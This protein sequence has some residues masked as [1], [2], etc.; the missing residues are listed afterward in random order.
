MAEPLPPLSPRAREA[1]ID[2][3]SR[4]FANDD[5]TLE[6]LERRI[7]RVYKAVTTADLEA[8]TADLRT[9][10]LPSSGGALPARSARNAARADAQNGGFVVPS[11][12]DA[13]PTRL[14][15]IMSTTRR[16]GRWSV[17][18]E[19][20]VLALMSDTRLDLTSAAMPGGVVTVHVNAIMASFRIIVP[21][22][23]RIINQMH[24]FMADVRS[25]ADEI[26]P[27]ETVSHD[28]PIIRLTGTA[29]MADVKITVRRR[30][31]PVFDDD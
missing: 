22:G 7:E 17:P 31:D 23:M 27:D 1:K 26:L 6:D 9:A 25:T 5:L 18:R 2:E 3:L 20:D 28:A 4:H 14:L 29:C 12:A 30:E 16:L 11:A 15:A 21:P 24:S 10:G 8:I 13:R 19:L